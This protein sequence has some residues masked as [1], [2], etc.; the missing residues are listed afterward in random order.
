M[1][2]R[3]A[4]PTT[5]VPV[6][7]IPALVG[8]RSW[9]TTGGD[10]TAGAQ[11]QTWGLR[12]SS[13]GVQTSPGV[14]RAPSERCAQLMYKLHTRSLHNAHA[15]NSDVTKE[16]KA[17]LLLTNS[18]KEKGANSEELRSKK[19]V[20]FQ[21]FVGETLGDVV[22]SEDD[23]DCTP[24]TIE[25]N[26]NSAGTATDA[27]PRIKP[28][29]RYANGSVVDSEAMGGISV[30]NGDVTPTRGGYQKRLPRDMLLFS[31]PARFSASQKICN[32]C[33]GRRAAGVEI[34]GR[35]VLT[36]PACQ[37][38]SLFHSDR[39]LLHSSKHL[40]LRPN[41]TDIRPS[42]HQL[43]E[44][45]P[46]RKKETSSQQGSPLQDAL[47]HQ[48]T[49]RPA[50]PLHSMKGPFLTHKHAATLTQPQTIHTI[51]DATIET[52]KDDGVDS[53]ANMSL[54]NKSAQTGSLPSTPLM[55]TATE[56]NCPPTQTHSKCQ[57]NVLQKVCVSVHATQEN[58]PSHLYTTSNVNSSGIIPKTVPTFNS[59]LMSAQSTPASTACPRRENA[60]QNST[61]AAQRT[62]TKGDSKVSP[63]YRIRFSDRLKSQTQPTPVN[64]GRTPVD[65][66]P[67]RREKN[68]LYSTVVVTGPVKHNVHLKANSN[69]SD[70][71]NKTQPVTSNSE[72]T[73]CGKTASRNASCA[74]LDSKLE[75]SAPIS[76]TPNYALYRNRALRSY[77][78]IH[79]SS[80]LKE[81][82]KNFSVSYN[83]SL[84][85]SK[86][87]KSMNRNPFPCRNKP[88]HTQTTDI[89]SQHT[90]QP[91]PFCFVPNP[92]ATLG[93][94]KVAKNPSKSCHAS[95]VMRSHPNR[96]DH[97]NK[98]NSELYSDEQLLTRDLIND[99]L[100]NESKK[101]PVLSQDTTPQNSIRPIKSK[102]SRLQGC[103]NGRQ[104]TGA[105]DQG[106][107]VREHEGQ[108]ATCPAGGT[109]RRMD[110]NTLSTVHASSKTESNAHK[111]THPNDP[112]ASV[113]AKGKCEPLFT[114]LTKR[115][116]HYE[117][118]HMQRLESNKSQVQ[119]CLRGS[120]LSSIAPE[121]RCSEGEHD[122]RCNS[123]SPRRLGSRQAEA[124]VGRDSK[125][126][127][128]QDTAELVS[129]R[130]H[131][132]GAVLFLPSSPRCGKSAT[133]Q[134]RLASVEA[135]LAANKDRINT[136]LNI[137][138]DLEASHTPATGRRC[139]KTGQDLKSCSTCQKNACIVYSVEYDFRQQE[140][141]F[142]E[143]LNVHSSRGKH[144]DRLPQSRAPNFSLLRK[145]MKNVTTSKK[146]SKKL[147]K[148]L[149]KWLP[150]KLKQV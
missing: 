81:N 132:T 46:S 42:N 143:V 36:A 39:D 18:D 121:L 111:Q 69:A 21:E 100:W 3:A 24:R 107:T 60:S 72:L 135:A 17:L 129:A 59:T 11:L 118:M 84:K 77:S 101:H 106:G 58:T 138:H 37:S 71:H 120:K 55:A 122:T 125:V 99:L 22:R 108:C 34:F 57:Y 79:P 19:E 83:S 28:A 131:P 40:Q 110:S 96:T 142:S 139:D 70:K 56:S 1:G 68:S 88:C 29:V 48:K 14:A 6:L 78:N 92:T 26:P 27:G 91:A 76:T 127:G 134:Q 45:C 109:A 66:A 136:L 47:R 86:H 67:T 98:L 51:T 12:S 38:E 35:N 117:L 124:I 140:R 103:V 141:R 63:K 146:T 130:S 85:T 133:V 97:S 105:H 90:H 30:D 80:T 126:A 13:V 116:V 16:Y 20:T 2:R 10:T 7:G 31:A 62:K 145:A 9:R 41:E 61:R 33:G 23:S 43:L 65:V 94:S 50:R 137:I 15:T 49:R 123:A 53:L 74:A 102:D 64:P 54:G 87:N 4:D 52:K 144:A 147:C 114:T 113:A 25:A 82:Q 32:Q 75:T 112:T 128:E 148:I 119:Q 8:A 5:P 73:L 95:N 115:N 104:Q 89:P 150:R 93:L 44:K 149:L